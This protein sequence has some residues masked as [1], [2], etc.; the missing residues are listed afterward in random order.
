MSPFRRSHPWAAYP[1]GKFY[2]RTGCPETLEFD[3]LVYFG[4]E[5]EAQAAGYLPAHGSRCP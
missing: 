2:Y 4:S 1:E 5:K 3:D